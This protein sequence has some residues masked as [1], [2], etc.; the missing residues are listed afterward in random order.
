VGLVIADVCLVVEGTYPYVRGGVSSWVH[1]LIC[2]MPELKFAILLV[3]AEREA[4][5][6]AYELPPNVVRFTEVFIHEAV[7]HREPTPGRRGKRRFWKS[8]DAFHG[9]P[10]HAQAGPFRE[11]LEGLA[12]PKRRVQTT[13][14]VLYSPRAWRYLVR[15]YERRCP[16]ESFI[17]FVWTWRAIHAPVMQILHAEIPEASVY[18]LVSTGYAGLA[19][20]VARLRY[21][22]PVLLTEHGIYVRE[23]Q[24]DIARADWIH[25]APRRTHAVRLDPGA[26]KSL[27]TRFFRRLGELT[28]AHCDEILTLFEGNR[29]L[30]IELGC[31]PARTRVV[32]NGVRTDVFAPLRDV[33]PIPDGVRR[34]ALVGRVVPIKDVKTF[35]KAC[36]LVASVRD[37]VA[38]FV[39][40]PTDEDP[41]YTAECRA[42][43]DSLGLGERLRFTGT[44]DVREW[45]PR[46]DLTVLTSVSEGQPLTVI[47]AACAGVPTV[48]TDVGAC[49]ELVE[50]ATAEDRALGPA[51]VVTR[52]GDPRGTAEAV[53]RILGDSRLHRQMA[54]AGARRAERFYREADVLAFY[55]ALYERWRHAPDAAMP[56]ETEAA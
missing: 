31:P 35:V 36:A 37:D 33:A 28:Y 25:E 40:G 7:N 17:D 51:G 52:V 9:C 45:L 12:D 11:V 50:G 8:V 46:L 42:L 38:F 47:E 54:L 20:M 18:H 13:D 29:Q 27:W 43:A 53:L 23:R 55:R 22:R 48:T 41:E 49:R 5:P 6:L 30:Q 26:M 44:I 34:I 1:A 32:P 14:D 19:G 15:R 2:G 3:S 10:A 4:R 56:A 24:I 39:C 16:D 21:R